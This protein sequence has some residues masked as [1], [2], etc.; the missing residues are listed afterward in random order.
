[1]TMIFGREWERKGERELLIIIHLKQMPQE[2]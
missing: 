2:C 1:M